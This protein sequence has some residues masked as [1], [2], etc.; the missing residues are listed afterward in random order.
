[1]R[2]KA[3]VWIVAVAIAIVAAVV[4]RRLYLRRTSIDGVTLIQDADVKR[5]APIPGVLITATVSD[6]VI[7]GSSD[8][9]GAFHLMVPREVWR[10]ETE[11][12]FRHSGYQPLNVTEGLR[13]KILVVRM[14]PV[15]ANVVVASSA[16]QTALKDVRVRYA[17]KATTPVNVGSVAKTFEVLNTGDVPCDR[18][19]PCSP[20]G[21]WKA[22]DGGFTLDAGEGH[23]FHNVRLSCIAGPCPFTSID[24]NQ[25]LDGGRI[26]KV[27]VRNWSDTVTFLAEAEVIQTMVTDLIRNAYP[28]IFGREMS[29]TLPP[30]SQGPSIE[31]ET[32]GTDIVY[33]L[34]PELSLSWAVCSQQ[35][36]AD[37]TKLYR[38]ELKP[39]Y[40]FE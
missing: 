3:V 20:N 4:I 2:K 21:K 24:S 22:A 33:P 18:A 13:G 15:S 28:A 38:C 30:M 32:N 17:S 9:A 23:Q 6:K 26:L 35:T 16:P 31:A 37:R 5:Q 34:G 40:R 10:T 36:G 39:G 1:M 11:L 14:T 7:R 19:A 29:F 8:A 25:L 27:S 12:Q